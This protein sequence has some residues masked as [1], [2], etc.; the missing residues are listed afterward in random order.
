L[1]RDAGLV[2]LPGQIRPREG[3]AWLVDWLTANA[4]TVGDALAAAIGA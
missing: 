4:T 1:L 3:R 2:V